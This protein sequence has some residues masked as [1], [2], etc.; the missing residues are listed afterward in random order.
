MLQS[1]LSSGAL[2]MNGLGKHD[3]TLRMRVWGI[4]IVRTTVSSISVIVQ[5]FMVNRIY[6]VALGCNRLLRPC[7]LNSLLTSQWN[8]HCIDQFLTKCDGILLLSVA[9]S[10]GTINRNNRLIG[11]FAMIL[12]NRLLK[13]KIDHLRLLFLLT[14]SKFPFK[15]GLAYHESHA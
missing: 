10:A 11:R 6:E 7:W 9:S 5:I 8:L 2:N 15:R 1:K 13:Q 4:L 3:R 14:W 12:I